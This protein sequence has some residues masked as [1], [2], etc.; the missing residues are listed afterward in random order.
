M[1]AL[2]SVLLAGVLLPSSTEQVSTTTRTDIASVEP[3]PATV[4]DATPPPVCEPCTLCDFRNCNRSVK[5]NCGQGS[6]VGDGTP[7]GS[8]TKGVC[9][10]PGR[11][12]CNFHSPG[13][14]TCDWTHCKNESEYGTPNSAPCSVKG[15]ILPVCHQRD[16]LSKLQHNVCT[17]HSSICTNTGCSKQRHHPRRY[18]V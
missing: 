7:R 17:H 6:M 11:R 14:T 5:F 15:C 3:T 1:A 4:A 16:E 8:C 12:C 2:V 13:V 18:I 9:G 10:L